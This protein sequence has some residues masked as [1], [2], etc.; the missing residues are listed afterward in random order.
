MKTDTSEKGL[1]SLIMCDMTGSTGL[2]F[3][4][5][6]TVEDAKPI[7]KGLGWFV[8]RPGEYDRVYAIDVHQLVL[9]LSGTQPDEFS[10]LGFSPKPDTKDMNRQKFL[11]RLQGEISRRGTIDVR[12]DFFGDMSKWRMS[13]IMCKAGCFDDVGAE[14]TK[15]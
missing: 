1:E 2:S 5:A 11:A 12:Q 8:G 10:K 14:A 7:A 15:G 9:F 13:E 3:A 6:S 4:G